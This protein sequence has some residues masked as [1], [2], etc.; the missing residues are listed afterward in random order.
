MLSFG[1]ITGHE[2]VIG[3]FTDVCRENRVAHAYMLSGEEGMGKLTLANAF[4]LQL[5]CERGGTEPC[6]ECASCRQV[7]DGNHP[8]LIYVTHEKP[9]SIGVDDIRSQVTDTVMIRP[10]RSAYKI[11]IID[12]A[13]KMTAQAQNALLKTLEEP[14]AYVIIL[15]LTANEEALLPTIRSRCVCLKLKPLSDETVKGYLEHELHTSPADAAIY[16]AFAR[17]NLG[18]AISLATSDTFRDSYETMRS[19]AK[20]TD[21]LDVSDMLDEIKAMR[22]EGTDVYDFLDFL[23]MWYRDI[24]IYKTTGNMNALIFQGDYK[25]IRRV[26]ERSSYTG[27]EAVLEAIDKA[28][29]RLRANVNTELALELLLLTIKENC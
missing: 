15:L 10:Y 25:A 28:R 9:A 24:L 29:T 1:G 8:D 13:E 21:A 22:D 16:A 27:I 12:E 3:Y 4:A 20:R 11:Y 18:K 23:Q 19:L 7:Q 26:S 14:P 2:D 5:L 6:M 17:G